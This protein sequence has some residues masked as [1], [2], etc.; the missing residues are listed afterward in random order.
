[1]TMNPTTSSPPWGRIPSAFDLR[2]LLDKLELSDLGPRLLEAQRKD[3]D[4]LLEAHRQVLRALEAL[5]QRQQEIVRA[6]FAAWQE[7]VREVI[8]APRLADKAQASARRTQQALRRSFADLRSLAELALESN[9]RVLGVFDE[10]AKARLRESGARSGRARVSAEQ[11][12]DDSPQARPPS[13]RTA[14]ARRT[15]AAA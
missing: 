3:L 2:K 12:A 15:E 1:M 5:G 13:R 14:A 6:A 9:R 8:A 10:R 4:A 7:A 11:V